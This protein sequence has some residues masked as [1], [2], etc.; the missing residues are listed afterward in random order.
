M[1]HRSEIHNLTITPIRALRDNYI[2]M[3]ARA[4]CDRVVIVDPGESAPVLS[5][6]GSAGLKIAAIL[7]THHHP[8]HV[9][10]IRRLAAE[11]AVQVFGPQIEQIPARTDGVADGDRVVIAALALEFRALSVPGHTL[12]AI[13][14]LGHGAVFSGDTLFTGGCGRLFEGTPKQ[15]C[16]SLDKLAALPKT[17][18]VYCGHEYT[19]ANM[20]FAAAVEPDNQAVM[21][22]REYTESRIAAGMPCVPSTLQCEIETNPFLRCRESSVRRAAESYSG[23]H[24]E[25]PEEVF[26]VIREW[27]NHFP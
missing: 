27:K 10:G 24:L 14:Y 19:L 13:A 6:L 1:N 15:M 11:A 20:M 21:E 12:G 16:A 18:N 3:I 25:R 2:W 5:V 23:R 22:R 26:A 7:V 8:D 4:G 17:T 9:A